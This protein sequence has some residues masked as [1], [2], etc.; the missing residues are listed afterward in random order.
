[1]KKITAVT[2]CFIMSAAAFFSCSGKSI[3]SAELNT[4]KTSESSESEASDNT[5]T[6]DNIDSH[7]LI[8][9][10]ECI[11]YEFE[12]RELEDYQGTPIAAFRYEILDGG[13]ARTLLYDD[14]MFTVDWEKVGD[15]KFNIISGE[16][17]VPVTLDNG[18]FILESGG[19][20][21]YTYKKV[22][23]FTELEKPVI[24]MESAD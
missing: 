24:T 16:N 18:C 17:I 11:R 9:K 13:K 7:D 8:G 1:M 21:L 3:S 12:G 4:T 19:G 15:N 2:L 14:E 5:D 10:W 23:E 6:A 20:A 22:S